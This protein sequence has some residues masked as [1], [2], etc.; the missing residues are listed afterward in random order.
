MALAAWDRV[1]VANR[2]DSGEVLQ[3]LLCPSV[4]VS[5]G[6]RRNIGVTAV[7]FNKELDPI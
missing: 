2:R 3:G 1:Q 7:T 4:C 6:R 5:V